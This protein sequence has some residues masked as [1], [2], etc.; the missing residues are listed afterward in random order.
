[1]HIAHAYLGQRNSRPAILG[2]FS[3]FLV[4]AVSTVPEAWQFSTGNPSLRS[5]RQV[6]IHLGPC[7]FESFGH[8]R[9]ASLYSRLNVIQTLALH[10]SLFTRSIR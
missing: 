9:H 6:E 10:G 4:D 2:H 5:F 3:Q 7:S 1:M 8:L